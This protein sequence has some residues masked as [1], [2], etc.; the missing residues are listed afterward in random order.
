MTCHLYFIAHCTVYAKIILFNKVPSIVNYVDASQLFG[1][2]TVIYNELWFGCECC[3]LRDEWDVARWPPDQIFLCRLNLIHICCQ[4]H[5]YTAG[6]FRLRHAH[7]FQIAEKYRIALRLI[8]TFLKFKTHINVETNGDQCS[9]SL[10]RCFTPGKRL[11]GTQLNWREGI[12][13]NVLKKR[14]SFAPVGNR[15]TILRTS[16]L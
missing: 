15:T 11:Y 8:F 13:L 14:K 9:V 2:Y 1:T 7:K 10:P 3:R 16:D 6:F 12:G 5:N 4:G